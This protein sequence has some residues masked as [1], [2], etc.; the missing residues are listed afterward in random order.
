MGLNMCKGV[1]QSL[2]EGAIVRG[3]GRIGTKCEVGIVHYSVTGECGSGR[4]IEGKCRGE[5]EER[6]EKK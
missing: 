3:I 6:K 5:G 2:G 4:D 1:V